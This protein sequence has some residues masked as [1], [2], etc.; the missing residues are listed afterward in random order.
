MCPLPAL[1]SEWSGLGISHRLLTMTPTLSQ[2]GHSVVSWPV[3]GLQGA[4]GLGLDH[5][6]DL[7]GPEVRKGMHW[8]HILDLGPSQVYYKA[9]KAKLSPPQFHTETG[10]EST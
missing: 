2:M 1:V 3:L 10:L 9:S 8:S 6:G 7:A 5:R 4:A